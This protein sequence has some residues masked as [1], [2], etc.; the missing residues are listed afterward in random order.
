MLNNVYQFS[1]DNTTY[2]ELQEY[3][4]ETL[5]VWSGVEGRGDG[6]GWGWG[7]VGGMVS[8]LAET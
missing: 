3:A 8:G 7:W 1:L 4:S 5:I 2:I 6:V